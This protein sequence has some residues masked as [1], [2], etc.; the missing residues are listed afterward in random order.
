VARTLTVDA[1]AYQSNL[2]ARVGSMETTFHA[3][4][5]SSSFA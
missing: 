2:D 3:G 1:K 5:K 4:F